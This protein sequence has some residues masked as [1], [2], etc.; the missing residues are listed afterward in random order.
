L[1]EAKQ[2]AQSEASRHNRENLLFGKIKEQIS[3]NFYFCKIS[4][5]EGKN[6]YDQKSQVY[7]QVG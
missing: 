4:D 3:Q 2:K 1:S 5:Q 7:Y 6:S